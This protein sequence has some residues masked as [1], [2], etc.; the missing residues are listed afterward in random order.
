[1]CSS[2]RR[3]NTKVPRA[4]QR[5]MCIIVVP[6]HRHTAHRISVCLTLAEA[7]PTFAFSTDPGPCIRWH[8]TTSLLHGR[9]RTLSRTEVRRQMMD[10]ANALA[11]TRYGARAGRSDQ[12][13]HERPRT[14][15]GALMHLHGGLVVGAARH[16]GDHAAQELVRRRSHRGTAVRALS[17]P[18]RSRWSGSSCGVK[19]HVQ[20][21]ELCTAHLRPRQPVP[22]AVS[23]GYHLGVDLGP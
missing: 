14:R 23:T 13:A 18:S 3:Q 7:R 21:F 19:Y 15:A 16:G 1:M 4:S 6:A 9:E 2:T 17:Y 22:T 20:A 8:Q 12:W 11:R 5:V 10:A